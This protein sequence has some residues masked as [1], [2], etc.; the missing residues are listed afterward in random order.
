MGSQDVA[1]AHTPPWVVPLHST[2]LSIAFLLWSATYILMT[3]RSLVTKSYG[4]PL[5]ALATNVS[6]EIV[7][8]FYVCTMPLEQVGLS[9]WL[10]LDIGLVYTTVKFGPQ[11]WRTS[12]PWIGR[13]IAWILTVLTA[14]GFIC[15]YSFS[16]WWLLE[17]QSSKK[18][19]WWRGR[20]GF[21]ITEL[22]FWS[23]GI[24]MVI[25]SWLSL[26]MLINRGHSG[27]TGYVIWF[28]RTLGTIIGPVLGYLPMWLHWP[29]A[30]AYVGSWKAIVL[31]GSAIACDFVYLFV[32]R[33]VRQSE[34]VLSDGRV[35]KGYRPD[36]DK[37]E[38]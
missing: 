17:P 29:E 16:A 34:L 10:V 13:N 11:E 12:N 24:S 36:P 30:H 32:L 5:V 25:T 21:D 14:V 35:I 23:S 1:P 15:H 4:M 7:N 8:L 9:M 2:L 6:W 22:A 33:S 3:R 19:K 28:C 37:K 27:G 31:W 20:E 38:V 18:G 26:F